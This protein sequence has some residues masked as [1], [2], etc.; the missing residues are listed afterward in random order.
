MGQMTAPQ[1]VFDPGHPIFGGGASSTVLHPL[2]IG[3]MVAI[4]VLAFV[5]PRRY[6]IVPLLFG[7]VVIPYG[8]SSLFRGAYLHGPAA[9]NGGLVTLDRIAAHLRRGTASGGLS[10][11]DKVF[12]VWAVY[13]FF[14]VLLL[15]RQAGM[16]PNQMDFLWDALGGYFLFRCLLRNEEDV[17]RA[18]KAI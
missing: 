14:A 7:I 17:V 12:I 5:L 15:F 16:I 18:L 6:V 13:R 10:K 2:V 4:A 9:G 3:L 1:S 8:Q 11:L